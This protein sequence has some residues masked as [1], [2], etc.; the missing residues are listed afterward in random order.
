MSASAGIRSSKIVAI[1]TCRASGA[2]SIKHAMPKN[3]LRV[4]VQEI[5]V[6]RKVLLITVVRPVISAPMVLFIITLTL[7]L[8]PQGRGDIFC[9]QIKLRAALVAALV[10]A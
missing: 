2:Y 10:G 4:R 8:S 1:I 5:D 6:A 3:T 7:A 9:A